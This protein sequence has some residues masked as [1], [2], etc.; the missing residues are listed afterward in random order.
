VSICVELAAS[1]VVPSAADPCTGY[2][3]FSA[4]EATTLL[5]NPF[6]LTVEQ[7]LLIGGAIAAVWAAAW[8]IRQLARVLQLDGA[9]EERE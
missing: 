9:A 8:C 5:S 1:A 6:L 7:G 3:L 2:V 4:A